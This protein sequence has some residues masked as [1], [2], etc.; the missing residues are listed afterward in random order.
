MKEEIQVRSEIEEKTGKEEERKC[1]NR[2]RLRF[3][4]IFIASLMG[5]A[6][7]AEENWWK[8]IR[9]RTIVHQKR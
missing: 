2:M 9:Q 3:N 6:F 5:S 1:G 7:I 8:W 4:C